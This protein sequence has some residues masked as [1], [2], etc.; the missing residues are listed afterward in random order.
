MEQG[1]L[2]T[3]RMV[4]MLRAGPLK[5]ASYQVM[6]PSTGE[7]GRI[8]HHMTYD[9]TVMAVMED[10]S[11]KMFANHVDGIHGRNTSLINA[12]RDVRDFH[13]A[14]GQPAPVAPE[15]QEVGRA[16]QR[17]IWIREECD[18]LDEVTTLE[19]PKARLIGQ[20]DAYL[21]ILYFAIG[22]LVECGVE[23]TILFNI[24][25]AANMA[26]LHDIDGVKT[27]VKNEVGKVIK[28]AGWVAP[29]PALQEEIERQMASAEVRLAA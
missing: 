26:K 15:A 7:Y 11:A 8:Q 17:G 3:V 19:D 28:P 22:G 24:V 27:P 1:I 4:K 18:E 29:E 6:D 5:L 20:V 14:F 16:K 12:F 10:E 13:Q 9:N 2:P 21:D 25:H 23:P